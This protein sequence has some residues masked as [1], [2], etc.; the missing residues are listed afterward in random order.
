M[1]FILPLLAV[2]V[3]LLI[4][5]G[6]LFHYDS[7][8]AV[9]ALS[10]AAAALMLYPRRLAASLSAVWQQTAGRWLVVLAALQLGWYIT[11]SATSTHPLTSFL[12]TNWRRLGAVTVL[13]M[14]ILVILAA[15][16]LIGRPE[17]AR[18]LLRV[19]A[20]VAIVG[21]LYGIAQYFDVDPFQVIAAYHAKDG[22]ATI[23]RPPGTLGHAD[24]FGWW[25]AISL[26]CALAEASIETT[27]WR[28]LGFSSAFLCGTAIL[29]SGTRAAILAALVG[30]VCLATLS[31]FRPARNHVLAGL[32][33]I[34]AFTALFLSPAGGYLRARV[35]WSSDESFGGGRPLLWRDSLRMAAVHPLTGFGPESFAAEFPPFQSV[36]LSRQ[37]PDFYHESPHNSALD[38]LV[39]E[40]IPGLVIFLGWGALAILTTRLC[41]RQR[42]GLQL[43]LISALAAAATVSLFSVVTAGTLFATLL[44]IALL[45]AQSSSSEDVFTG[46]PSRR[47]P[48]LLFALSPILALMLGAFGL[49]LLNHEFRLEQFERISGRGDPTRA[50]ASYKQ[51]QA[52]TPILRLGL[53]GTGEDAYCSRRLAA[54]CGAAKTPMAR[55]ECARMATEAAARATS[56]SDN[57][58]NAWYNLAMF[59][60]AMNDMSGTE[61]ALRR[62]TTLSPN[63]FKPHWALANLLLIKGSRREAATEAER[64]VLLDGGKDP[65]VTSS[66]RAIAQTR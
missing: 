55:F 21:S 44:V 57:P 9:I 59:T 63:W 56:T 13:S 2:M 25:L 39:G 18:L 65:E 31:R 49:V 3:P 66:L 6:L 54:L 22:D 23:V 19:M 51:L 8:P 10:L 27:A 64:A 36:E 45:I 12:G 11:T 34:A 32:L 17:R 33:A 16:H 1:S 30:L 62:A 4:T 26:F 14:M 5:P 41:L 24:Y 46:S 48:V 38:A 29:L 60:A 53:A 37:L 52:G 7:A 40:G 47:M 61:K 58:S 20:V 43:A 42:S 50:I 15:A 28:V 35:R